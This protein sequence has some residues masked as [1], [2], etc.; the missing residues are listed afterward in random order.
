MGKVSLRKHTKVFTVFSFLKLRSP[1][2]FYYQWLYPTLLFFLIVGFIKFGESGFFSVDKERLI[3]DINALVSKLAG[4][5]I[6]ALAAVSSFG[7]KSL[8]KQMKGRAPIL[9]SKRKGQQREN[10]TR[11]R[12]LA[13]L[14]GYCT[15]LTIILYLLGILQIHLNID[16]SVIEFKKKAID[17]ASQVVFVLYLWI[18]CSLIVVTLLAL[19]YLVERMYRD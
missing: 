7:S 16:Q 19:H 14:F 11:R 6:A 8:D 9:K 2:I 3:L 10:L 15:G 5:Y 12:F 4:F 18:I 1:D 13:I 17:V